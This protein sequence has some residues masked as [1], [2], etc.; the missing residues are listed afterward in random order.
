MTLTRSQAKRWTDRVLAQASF[1]D[2]RVRIT[3]ERSGHL[4]FAQ[5]QPTTEGDVERLEI[6]VTAAKDGRAAT[7]TGNRTDDAGLAQ[8]VRA[9]EELAELAPPDPEFMPPLGPTKYLTV[10]GTDRTTA[11]MAAAQRAVAVGAALQTARDRGVEAAGFLSHGD[12]ASAVADRAG[13]FAFHPSTHVAMTTTCRTSDGTGSARAGFRSHAASGLHAGTL[14]EDAARRALQSQS[15][16]PIEPGRY[17]V[18]LTADAVADLLSFFTSSMDA[19][20]AD[21]G[22][23][24]FSKPGGGNRAGEL[25]FD[26]RISIVSDPANA[27]HPAAPFADDGRPQQ[28]TSWVE[29][30]RL[31]ALPASRYWADKQ[32][33]ASR[34]SPSSVHMAGT[35]DDLDALIAKVD[36]GILVSRFWYNRMLARSSITATGLTRDG[37]FLIEGGRLAKPIGNLRYND[38]PITLLTQVEALGRPERAAFSGGDVVVVPPMVVRDFNFESTSD[39]I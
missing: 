4:R 28:R 11:K 27:Q 23:S 1:G 18:V 26:P 13:L 29:A 21:E 10:R 2:V 32:G 22:R 34:P 3:D 7:V 5:G 35:N 33:I 20:A 12:R 25:L 30:G 36:R 38:S 39:A 15:P 19:R 31:L 16:S 14:A 8:L 37:T 24:W 17:T 6:R 9:A